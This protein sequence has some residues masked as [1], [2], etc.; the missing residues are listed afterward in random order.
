MALVNSNFRRLV[1]VL[2]DWVELNTPG[3]HVRKIHTEFLDTLNGTPYDLT[4]LGP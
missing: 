2:L 1:S 3:L 4:I